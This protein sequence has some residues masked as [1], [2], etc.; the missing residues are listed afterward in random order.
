MES[1]GRQQV[2][3]L[4]GTRVAETILAS[5]Q[6]RP[7]QQAGHMDASDPIRPSRT[8]AARGP[9]TYG[10]GLARFARAPGMTVATAIEFQIT[11]P[12]PSGSSLADHR[13]AAGR[14][15]VASCRDTASIASIT[16][17]S[18]FPALKSISMSAQSP[19]QPAAP[20][21]GIDAAVG[22]DLDLTVGQQRIRSGCR[23]CAPR[24]PKFAGARRY[25]A[26]TRRAD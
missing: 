18:K 1:I 8:L 14:K 26:P 3:G 7:H 23:C 2:A 21:L 4:F 17:L 24:Y 25:R 12:V 10:F 9:S 22:D 15:C 19:R 11:T 13:H 16:P 5:G 6:K 20:T